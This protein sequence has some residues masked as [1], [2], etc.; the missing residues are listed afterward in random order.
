MTKASKKH[1][2]KRAKQV[3]NSDI[4]QLYT[5]HGKPRMTKTFTQDISLRKADKIITRKKVSVDKKELM[6]YEY[7]KPM[8]GVTIKRTYK[9]VY[10]I[11]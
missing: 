10:S 5:V 2:K 8:F 1:A 6:F 9:K 4:G 7:K 11:S 3:K